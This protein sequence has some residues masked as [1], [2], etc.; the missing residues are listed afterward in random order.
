MSTTKYRVV[1]CDSL[2]LHSSPGSANLVVAQVQAGA[3]LAVIDGVLEVAEDVLWSCVSFNGNELWCEK[4]YLLN[5]S[6]PHRIVRAAR[7][8]S[9]YMLENNWHYRHGDLEPSISW[10]ET[11]NTTKVSNAAYFVSWCAQNAGVIKKGTMISHTK[12]GVRPSTFSRVVSGSENIVHGKT[13]FPINASV[14][15]YQENLQFGDIIVHDSSIGIYT[16]MPFGDPNI[17]SA[18]SGYAIN[19]SN[20]YV[21]LNFDSGYEFAHNILAVIRPT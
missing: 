6:R 10:A 19:E 21:K 18:R 12:K 4:Q 14:A 15:E 8:Y 9:N 2:N 7:I 13:I 17:I 11:K 20:E 3:I 5:W 16:G 1:D